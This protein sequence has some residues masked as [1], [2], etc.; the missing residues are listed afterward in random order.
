MSVTTVNNPLVNPAQ[1][2]TPQPTFSNYVLSSLNKPDISEVATFKYGKQY[3]ICALLDRLTRSEEA[4][5]QTFSWFEYGFTRK[6]YTVGAGS[7]LSAGATITVKI[8]NADLTSLT[9]APVLVPTM[10]VRFENGSVGRISTVTQNGSD[11]DV[12]L[13]PVGASAWVASGGAAYNNVPA[14]GN[15]FAQMYSTN[16]EY[17]DAPNPITWNPE[18]LNNFITTNRRTARCSTTENSNM[19]WIK[20]PKTG[21][22]Y[23]SFINESIA[24]EETMKDKEMLYLMGVQSPTATS[25]SAAGSSLGLVPNILNRGSVT[26]YTGALQASDIEE[27]IRLMIV[28]NGSTSNEWTV[29]CGSQ[30]LRDAQ[31][32]LRFYIVNGAVQYTATQAMKDI[33]LNFTSYDFMGGV[34][35]LVHYKPFDNPTLFPTPAAAG[36]INFSKAAL[37]LNMGNDTQGVPLLRERYQVDANGVAYKFIRKVAPGMSAPEPAT[38]MN[39]IAVNGLDGFSVFFL[40]ATGLEMRAANSHGF[41]FAA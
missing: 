32:A 11:V 10:T 31:Q 4:T 22:R 34:L 37:F 21:K 28:A 17:S 13:T 24:M 35:H 8:L 14:S 40:T 29:L 41:Q 12:V 2:G 9:T 6:Q 5:Q 26:T 15:R 7:T 39:N 16:I 23:Y 30:W 19:K 25:P 27:Q 18:Q 3:Q 38:T 1:T 20:D 33:K 36:N